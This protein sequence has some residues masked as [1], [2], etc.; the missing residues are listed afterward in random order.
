MIKS[1]LQKVIKFTN[2]ISKEIAI[3]KYYGKLFEKLCKTIKEFISSNLAKG[4]YRTQRNQSIFSIKYS[5][6]G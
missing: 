5:K 1:G 3:N 4:F 6:S 2:L